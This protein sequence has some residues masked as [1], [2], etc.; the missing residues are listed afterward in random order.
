VGGQLAVE[1]EKFRQKFAGVGLDAERRRYRGFASLKFHPE[2][3]RSG[4]P[5]SLLSILT[6]QVNYGD[7]STSREKISEYKLE[8]INNLIGPCPSFNEV[9]LLSLDTTIT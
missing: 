1:L 5:P 4:T 6:G 9:F 3:S 2:P 7:A 8:H